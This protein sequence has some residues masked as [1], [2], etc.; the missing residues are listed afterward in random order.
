MGSYRAS[1]K[2]V[3]RREL[4]ILYAYLIVSVVL[5]L[6]V[7]E[8]MHENWQKSQFINIHVDKVIIFF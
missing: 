5:K 3:N 7:K 8:E 4:T 2:L 6:C 1:C